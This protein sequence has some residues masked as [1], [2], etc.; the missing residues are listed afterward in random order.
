V[1]KRNR[2]EEKLLAQ[3]KAQIE[4][5]R[6]AI[7]TEPSRRKRSLVAFVCHFFQAVKETVKRQGSVMSLYMVIAD[8]AEFGLPPVDEEVIRKARERNAEAIISVE[9]FHSEKDIGD[10]VYHISMSAPGLGVMGWIL[11]VKIQ[12]GHVSFERER[13][14]FFQPGDRVKSLGELLAETEGDD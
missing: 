13:P 11:K 1:S 10:V 7:E 3:M 4:Q 2:E 14:Y 9:G 12:N 6:K 8:P 5:V